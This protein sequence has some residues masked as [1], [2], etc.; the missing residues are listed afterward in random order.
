[1]LTPRAAALALALA[2]P[3]LAGPTFTVSFDT[4]TRAAPATGRLIIYLIRD[5]DPGLANADPSDGPFWGNPQPMF[6][7]DVAGLTPGAAAAVG[8]SAAFYPIPINELAPGSYRAQ[9]VLDLHR[10]NSAWRRE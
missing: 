9:A 7:V 1:M 2:A 6:G 8:E 5:G 3:A 10:D 4:A